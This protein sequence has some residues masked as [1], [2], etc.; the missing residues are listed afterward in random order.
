MRCIRG[1]GTRAKQMSEREENSGVNSA[2]RQFP[3]EPKAEH[4]VICINLNFS[5]SL[6]L[7]VC[8]AINVCLFGCLDVC[9]R[10]R[11]NSF[12]FYFDFNR[13]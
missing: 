2:L 10:V 7:A 3:F 12:L 13:M 8:V 9:V 1:R 4:F 6:C 5:I 11:A